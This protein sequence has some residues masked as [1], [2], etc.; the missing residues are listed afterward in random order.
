MN[1]NIG[2]RSNFNNLW[3]SGLTDF[4]A[5]Y[6]TPLW[7]KSAKFRQPNLNSRIFLL[8]HVMIFLNWREASTDL[9]EPFYLP[10]LLFWNLSFLGNN[11]LFL[12]KKNLFTVSVVDFSSRFLADLD[13][14]EG[15]IPFFS[16]NFRAVRT[17][18]S[19]TS[20][21]SITRSRDQDSGVSVKSWI[22]SE[23]V[24]YCLTFSF[25]APIE[26]KFAECSENSAREWLTRTYGD[27]KADYNSSTTANE[28]LSAYLFI[29]FKRWS[30]LRLLKLLVLTGEISKR[31]QTLWIRP[32]V[33]STVLD[34][35]ANSPPFVLWLLRN[36]SWLLQFSS[37]LLMSSF[38]LSRQSSQSISEGWSRGLSFKSKE[39]FVVILYVPQTEKNK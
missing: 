1:Q 5:P 6:C 14:K 33:V 23:K 37:W 32:R 11:G 10:Y 9:L 16:F 22:L 8:K 36:V 18:C 30:E 3:W 20:N 34:R 25:K 15:R 26:S 7:M 4:C 31:E 19:D 24:F 35:S 38:S 39:S 28:V 17:T 29:T 13:E 27:L 2:W 12:R 21:S